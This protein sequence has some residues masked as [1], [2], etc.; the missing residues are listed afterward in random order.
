MSD[1]LVAVA[2]EGL[3][4]L[5]ERLAYWET[6]RM[7]LVADAHIGKAATFRAGG[8]PVPRGTTREGLDRL[9]VAILRTGATRVVF[10][11]D[12]LHAREGRDP[13]TLR[14]LSEWRAAHATLEVILVRG[15]HDRGAGDPPVEAGIQCV[16]APVMDGPFVLAHYPAPHSEGYVLAGHL[17]PGAL[18]A[19]PARQWERLPCFW[20][21]SQ[22]MVLPAFGD[23][24]GLANIEPARDDR[25][26]V[27]GEGQ[28]IYANRRIG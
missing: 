3:R 10:L 28:V 21:G 25:V 7:L 4:L 9:D 27:V 13:E 22:V 8:I 18:L 11:G 15:N 16:D 6:R 1:A 20:V 26:Y 5:P 2:G 19:G 17:H 14:A 12:L 24:T 23:F